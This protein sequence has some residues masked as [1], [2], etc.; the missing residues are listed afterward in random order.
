MMRAFKDPDRAVRDHEMEYLHDHREPPPGWSVFLGHTSTVG[1]NNESRYAFPTLQHLDPAAA[2]VT[3]LPSGLIVPKA[4]R[5]YF[6]AHAVA[7][8]QM[9]LI[10][11]GVS[12]PEANAG[13]MSFSDFMHQVIG[14]LRSDTAA[15]TIQLWPQPTAFEW[16]RDLPQHSIGEFFPLL[17]ALPIIASQFPG[18]DAPAGQRGVF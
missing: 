5:G 6:Q 11:F 14:Q 7:V 2:S 16:P 10:T 15:P 1:S 8:Q 9:L 13:K 18:G 3:E 4:E 12:G 17:G